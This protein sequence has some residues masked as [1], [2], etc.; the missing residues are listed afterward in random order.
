MVVSSWK[1]VALV[2]DRRI[3]H[4]QLEVRMLR[5]KALAGIAGRMTAASLTSFPRWGVISRA[6][7]LL[8]KVL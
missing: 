7:T 8:H 6:T 4:V 5:S 2:P 1:V 3:V